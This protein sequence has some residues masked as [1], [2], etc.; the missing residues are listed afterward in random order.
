[1]K[2]GS[3]ADLMM[4][5]N[6]DFQ[7]KRIKF[8]LNKS[9]RE[10]LFKQLEHACNQMQR[11]LE[12]DDQIVNARQQRNTSKPKRLLDRKMNDFWKYAQQLHEA[13]RKA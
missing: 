7:T 11:L 9:T 10:R 13:L 4:R 8:S 5:A 2:N 12:L 6:F 1:M 3:R